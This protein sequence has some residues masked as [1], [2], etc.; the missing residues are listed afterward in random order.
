MILFLEQAKKYYP[1][2]VLEECKYFVKEKMPKYIVK[3]VEMSPDECDKDNCYEENSDEETSNESNS[4]QENHCKRKKVPRYIN[5]G[6]KISSDN[7][8]ESDEE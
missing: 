7:S 1:Q 8:D 4:H 6:L 3:D 5:E 2:V